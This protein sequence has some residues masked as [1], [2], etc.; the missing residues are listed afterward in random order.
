MLVANIYISSKLNNVGCNN[1]FNKKVVLPLPV[2]PEIIYMHG[3]GIG[4][5]F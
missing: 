4:F 5:I 3:S 1:S 2:L